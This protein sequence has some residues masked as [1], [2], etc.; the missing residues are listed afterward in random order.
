MYSHYSINRETL[1]DIQ[2]HARRAVRGGIVDPAMRKLAIAVIQQ[3]IND[4][5]LTYAIGKGKKATEAERGAALNFLL[6]T[7]G[8]VY[9]DRIFW[10]ERIVEHCRE[11]PMYDL[12]LRERVTV[13]LAKP[14]K[15]EPRGR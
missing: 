13:M 12:A 15:K 10:L 8:E 9:E 3:A 2:E 1:H 5:T 11:I 6:A 14:K 4:A 7:S